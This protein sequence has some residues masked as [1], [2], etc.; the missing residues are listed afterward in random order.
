MHTILAQTIYRVC[1]KPHGSLISARWALENLECVIRLRIVGHDAETPFY[2][3][4]KLPPIYL[5]EDSSEHDRKTRSTQVPYRGQGSQT[6]SGRI[7]SC[8][9]S[10]CVTG[11]RLS[12]LLYLLS[13]ASLIT[14]FS[15][16]TTQ[17]IV[18]RSETSRR[19]LTRTL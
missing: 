9:A 18:T 3:P 5:V 16:A 1:N 19:I 14:T 17:N 12:I 4:T 15:T 11:D 6:E 10:H 13:P 8:D 7:P 2:S